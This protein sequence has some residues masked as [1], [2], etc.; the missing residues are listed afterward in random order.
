MKEEHCEFEDNNVCRALACYSK[1]SCSARDADGVPRYSGH[2]SMD[3]I[4]LLKELE[5]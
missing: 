4:K 5:N 1:Q 3:D 2:K